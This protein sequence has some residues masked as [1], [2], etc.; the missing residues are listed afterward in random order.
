MQLNENSWHARLYKVMHDYP[1]LPE[2][3]CNYFWKLVL[4]IITLPLYSSALLVRI[5]KDTRRTIRGSGII[6]F[7]LGVNAI[8]LA[9]IACVHAIH[10]EQDL[11]LLLS[12]IIVFIGIPVGVV[13]LLF[14]VYLID[15][16]VKEIQNKK[17]DEDSIVSITSE[18]IK[19][20]KENYCPRIEWR[21]YENSN[22]DYTS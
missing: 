4:I 5:R 11:S 8:L 22:R 13:L 10:R 3:L 9:L 19:A 21:K 6:V 18:Y 2:D 7:G 1:K 17:Q 14:A 15:R 12:T 20:K 16:G